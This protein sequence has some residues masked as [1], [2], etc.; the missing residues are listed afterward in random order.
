M[1]NIIEPNETFDFTKLSLAHPSGIQGGAYFTKILYNT[2]PL[3]I[4][5]A[6]SLTRQAFVKSGKKYYCDLMF[7]NTAESMIHWFENL[8]DKCQKLLLEKNDAWFQ[9]SLTSS[10]IECAFTPTLRVYKS[11]KYYLIRTNIKNTPTGEPNIK[12]FNEN[13]VTLGI[14][15]ITNETNIISILEIQ[16]IKFTSRSF[17]IDIDLKQVMVV[18]RTPIFDNCVIKTNKPKPLE[19]SVPLVYKDKLENLD[20][21]VQGEGVQGEGLQSEGVQGEE[22]QSKSER[23]AIG[24]G[25]DKL[26]K[27]VTMDDIIAETQD[28]ENNEVTLEVE[29]LGLDEIKEVSPEVNL[30]DLGSITL[31]NP[32]EVYFDLYR[33]ARNKAKQAKRS[34][35]I[36][37]LEAKNI[38]KTYM[39][40]NLN[41]SDSEFDAEIDEASESELE[42]L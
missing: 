6:N 40:D 37:Y 13:E 21:G 9:N 18:D 27:L 29:E 7:D 19:L 35:I 41:D 36:A 25:Q 32:N 33:E 34:A 4:Q 20:E 30:D 10:D 17:Q 38:K 31:R 42:G 15:D 11:G 8:E 14:N 22:L 24:E 12:I 1:D 3:Y 2:K 16:G 5:T 28:N 23:E 26:N 39:L